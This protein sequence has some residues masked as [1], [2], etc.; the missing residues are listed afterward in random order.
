MKRGIVILVIL[1]GLAV[2]LSLVTCATF[3]AEQKGNAVKPSA[4]RLVI[5]RDTGLYEIQR[6]A[7]SKHWKEKEL[8]NFQKIGK[9]EGIP[10]FGDASQPLAL[11]P[12]YSS[13]E[14]LFG[15]S[16]SGWGGFIQ[17]YAWERKQKKFVSRGTYTLAQTAEIGPLVFTSWVPSKA[18]G[19]IMITGEID[20]P[21]PF[22]VIKL[23]S[24]GRIAAGKAVDTSLA[25][26]EKKLGK[27]HYL[28]AAAYSQDGSIFVGANRGRLYNWKRR[29][30]KIMTI[31]TPA[32]HILSLF[33][34]RDNVVVAWLG[35][36]GP[37]SYKAVGDFPTPNAF[38]LVRLDTGKATFWRAGQLKS[39]PQG[40]ALSKYLLDSRI[41]LSKGNDALYFPI[42]EIRQPKDWKAPVPKQH[43]ARFDIKRGT[44][45][46]IAK[47]V[48]SFAVP[49]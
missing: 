19:S 28:S 15:Q 4:E 38:G 37:S 14:I 41:A 17:V 39:M 5:L 3:A 20:F 6:S 33:I 29:L 7:K 1:A 2:A 26:V 30:G 11:A 24:N 31:S 25:R 18:M 43:L 10:V 21:Y 35:E 27:N 12:I 44:I 42:R 40:F 34:S 9:G 46:I 8:V 48:R 16:G 45:E 23:M 22:E 49:Y 36:E 47:D 13:S 32:N